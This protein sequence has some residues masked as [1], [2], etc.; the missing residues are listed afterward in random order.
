MAN[1]FTGDP[2]CVALWRF[3][4]TN[5]LADSIGTNDISDNNTIASNTTDHIEGAGCADFEQLND[6]YGDILDADLSAGFPFKSGDT[7][8]KI[9]VCGRLK[10]E[11]ANTTQYI[12]C[13]GEN[14]TNK[15][16]F[17]IYNNNNKLGVL[18][19]YSGGASFESVYLT[20]AVLVGRF[21]S[22][23]A[24]YDDSDKSY[25]LRVWDH[26]A[27]ALLQEITGNFTNN[28]NIED[29]SLFIGS[30]DGGSVSF[31][32]LMD[33]T[34]VFN[35][36]KTADKIDQIR[37]GTYAPG[38]SALSPIEGNLA[39]AVDMSST[40]MGKIGSGGQV[41]T[42]A[43]QSIMA[44][45]GQEGK[46]GSVDSAFEAFLSILAGKLG[47]QGA[48]DSTVSLTGLLFGST[49]E[50]QPLFEGTLSGAAGVMAAELSGQ[51]GISGE[52]LSQILTG[53]SLAGQL[54]GSG[55]YTV[56]LAG[57][58]A[59]LDGLLGVSGEISTSISAGAD[60]AGKLGISAELVA[61][62]SDFGLQLIEISRSERIYQIIISTKTGRAV[63]LAP[64]TG[65]INISTTS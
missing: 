33:E 5:L 18:L 63:F 13:K 14:G 2:N 58:S 46:Q 65:T 57:I 19:G 6:E 31:D 47:N 4:P 22:Y 7:N 17:A 15:R 26:T 38:G 24:T 25:R 8:K 55:S 48:I 3:E 56:Q 32:G 62:L 41:N 64:K 36:I 61:S 29:G 60:M 27:D 35:D 53:A 10:F 20:S 59:L 42:T 52:L 40:M 45:A 16:S 43:G 12:L 51:T 44:Q 50:V 39:A 54:G 30:R 23:G 21:Y 11:T 34:V 9:T 37:A 28:V 49:G 1:D